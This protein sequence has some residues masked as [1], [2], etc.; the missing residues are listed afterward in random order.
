MKSF[1]PLNENKLFEAIALKEGLGVALQ[2]CPQDLKEAWQAS[3][4]AKKE[5]QRAINGL[6][7]DSLILLHPNNNA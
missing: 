7:T 5:L 2:R 4:T 3:E 6:P 1:K